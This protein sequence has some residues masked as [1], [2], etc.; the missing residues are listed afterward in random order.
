MTFLSSLSS[1]HAS[2]GFSV[3]GEGVP[4]VLLHSSMSSKAQWA[5]LTERMSTRYKVIAI[6]LFG[7]GD[8]PMPNNEEDYRLSTEVARIRAVL[9][10]LL[11]P[12]E[13]FHL[14]GHAFGGA[15]A[16]RLAHAER[17][18]VI[19][20][21]LFEPTAFHLLPAAALSLG[22][23]M[24]VAQ[25]VKHALDDDA[26][27]AGARSYIDFWNGEESYNK[28]SFARQMQFGSQLRKVDLDFEALMGDPL[29]A[30]DYAYI[31]CPVLVML[32]K[33]GR[34]CT[35]AIAAELARHH[36]SCLLL[37]MEGGHMAP[38][39]HGDSVNAE[40]DAFITMVEA[41]AMR[42]RA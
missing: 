4:L 26:H 20:V 29:S 7:Y 40:I 41:D 42:A 12:G 37:E 14:A 11:A 25:R 21:A 15:V 8:V 35:R 5:S 33:E 27:T 23:V 6:D 28:F 9:T 2:F 19:S 22:E 31:P 17:T 32:G 24:Q 16:L 1:T 39:T 13:K 34:A 38:V 3:K 18:R 36:P 10:K 30:Y